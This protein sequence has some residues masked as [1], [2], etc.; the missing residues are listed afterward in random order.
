MF[1]WLRALIHYR[2]LKNLKRRELKLTRETN[3]HKAQAQRWQRVTDA[4]A[5][6]YELKVAYHKASAEAHARAIADIQQFRRALLSRRR[7][8]RIA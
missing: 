7:K 6:N 4:G 3:Y 1:R 5:V 2:A 8:R